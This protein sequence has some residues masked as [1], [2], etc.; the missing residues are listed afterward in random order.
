MKNISP[1]IIVA[2]VI[3]AAVAFFGGIKY[4]Q[5]KQPDV[6]RQF[7][8]GQGARGGQFAGR[9]G[10]AGFRPVAGEIIASDDK[11]ITVK[12]QDG[13]SKIV[14]ISGKTQINKASLAKRDELKTGE[15]VAIF[16]S[17]NTDGSITAQNVQLNPMQRGMMGSPGK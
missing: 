8:S 3:V 5:T 12:L 2:L 7:G 17:E 9:N 11:S 14:L 6:I 1:T 16:G 4:Q 10:R 13:S 15:K